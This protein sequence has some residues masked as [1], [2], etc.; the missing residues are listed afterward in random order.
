[1]EKE[2]CYYDIGKKEGL[3]GF[4]LEHYV[5]YMKTRWPDDEDLKCKNG[6]AQEWADRFVYGLEWT[7]S[8][9]HGR[10]ILQQIGAANGKRKA[11][12]NT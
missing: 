1:M 2:L 12:Q 5:V 11:H 8:D 9:S 3:K 7:A 4:R 10:L 6:Y